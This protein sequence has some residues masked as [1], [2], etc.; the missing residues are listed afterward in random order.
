MAKAAKLPVSHTNIISD[1]RESWI[2]KRL[3]K[4]LGLSYGD[5]I[6]IKSKKKTTVAVVWEAAMGDD[7][8]SIRL[9]DLMRHNLGIKVGDMVSVRKVPVRSARSIRLRP[10]RGQKFAASENFPLYVKGRLKERPVIKGDVIP[11]SVSGVMLNL[12]VSKVEPL[13]VVRIADKTEVVVG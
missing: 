10:P 4:K 9:D 2:D 6:Q 1:G 13:G 8:E 11:V 3:K 12:T 7:K 5:V